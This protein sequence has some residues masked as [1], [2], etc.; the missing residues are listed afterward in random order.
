MMCAPLYVKT[1]DFYGGGADLAGCPHMGYTGT[2]TRV[3]WLKSNAL[4]RDY[5]FCY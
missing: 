5:R 4:S 2:E 3:C 1:R